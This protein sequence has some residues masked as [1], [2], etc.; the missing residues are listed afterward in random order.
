MLKPVFEQNIHEIP[1][2]QADYPVPF[3]HHPEFNPPAHGVWN[4]VHVG[5][6]LPEAHQIYVC[7]R[8]CMRGVVLT[9]AEMNCQNRFSM[10]ILE[11]ED[12]LEGSIEDVTIEGT[13]EVLRNLP[14]LPPVVLLF[15]VCT[16]RFL[17]CDLD[18]IFQT[19]AQRFPS[20]QFLRCT[21][22]PITQ[23]EGLTP[24]QRLRK[25]IY[26]PLRSCPAL[27]RTA[28]I[29]GGDF[30]LDETSD[31]KKMLDAGGW[32]V[33]EIQNYDTYKA[34]QEM[35][36]A[37]MIFSVFPRGK[38]GAEE[39]ARRLGRDHVYLPASFSYDEIEQMEHMLA[40]KLT[41][42][43]PN[44]EL[45][46]QNCEE[47]LKR[48]KNVIGSTTISIDYTVHPR[49]LGLAR[50][51]ISHSFSVDTVYLDSITPEERADF[52]WLQK[53]A[54][55]LLIRSTIQP[56]A[57]V[58]NRGRSEK[59]LAIGQIA[60]WMEAT[61]HFINLVEGGGL[62]GFDGICRIAGLMTD[63]FLTKKDARDL[64]PRK[65]LGCESCI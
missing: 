5:M 26:E 41:L 21:M 47:A 52:L 50:L 49:P 18:Y 27:P 51:L 55:T 19:L 65:G 46:K 24:D 13:A 3:A 6:L 32:R 12:L 14:M 11:E 8:N 44:C 10:V 62:W 56:Q 45:G 43:A 48:A 38:Y 23:K 42:P 9:A 29:L 15:T 60:A 20:V 16:H 36:Q 34:Y 53:H 1:I 28:A 30:V 22:E 57:R 4:I 25:T 35:A 63:A 33:F 64:V 58:R 37:Q 39:T 59:H 54:G 2:A 7:G 40:K 17:G 31:L 61:P